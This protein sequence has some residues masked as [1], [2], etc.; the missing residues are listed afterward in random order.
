M[1]YIFSYYKNDE[2]KS[3]VR[4]HLCIR[5]P[6]KKMSGCGEMK[7]S[8]MPDGNVKMMNICIILHKNLYMTV[9]SGIIQP[10]NGNNANV[11]QMINR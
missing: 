9:N 1:L 2:E 6:N 7:F 11:H 4:N 3:T 10:R 8:F 5:S